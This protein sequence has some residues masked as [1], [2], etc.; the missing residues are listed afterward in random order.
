VSLS[1]GGGA[2]VSC[3]QAPEVFGG[4]PLPTWQGSTAL[5]V[6][7]GNS[8]QIYTAVEYVGGN[9]QSNS[10]VAAAWATFGNGK[11][12]LEQT[13]PILMGLRAITFDSRRQWGVSRMGYAR[14]REIAGTYTFPARLASLLRASSGSATLAWSGNISTFW[15]SQPLHFGRKVT[16]PSIRE[17]GNFRAGMPEGMSGNQQDAWPTMQRLQLSLRVV[18]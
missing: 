8:W 17:N 1:A 15:R 13:D 14:L 10:E 12:W 2:P 18:P 5:T 16:D 11:A 9:Y 3:A 4:A 7:L 6:S